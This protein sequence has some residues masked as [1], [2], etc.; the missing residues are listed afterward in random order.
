MLIVSKTLKVL[1]LFFYFH[2]MVSIAQTES[3]NVL[4]NCDLIY[5]FIYSKFHDKSIYIH[6]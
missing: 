2:V 5:L 3:Y 4:I 1:G 6:I